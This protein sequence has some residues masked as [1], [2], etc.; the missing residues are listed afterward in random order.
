MVV[1]DSVPT[2]G[3]LKIITAGMLCCLPPWLEEDQAPQLARQLA[4]NFSGWRLAFYMEP[5]TVVKVAK[6]VDNFPVYLMEK[7]FCFLIKFATLSFCFCLHST[8][9][10]PVRGRGIKVG[11]LPCHHHWVL[12]DSNSR[13]S[14][15]ALCILTTTPWQLH[16]IMYKL[17]DH[18]IL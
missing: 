4:G 18:Y 6:I 12:G 17:C 13:L 11:C 14:V 9:L 2:L 1:I 15:C 10:F 3:L 5:G 7:M 8:L 16:C